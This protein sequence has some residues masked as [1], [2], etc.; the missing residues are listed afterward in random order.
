[1]QMNFELRFDRMILNLKMLRKECER[2]WRREDEQQT[3]LKLLYKPHPSVMDNNTKLSVA[4][5]KIG[6]F[7]PLNLVI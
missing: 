7:Q 6:M 1:M 3:V 4:A 2:S 5:M